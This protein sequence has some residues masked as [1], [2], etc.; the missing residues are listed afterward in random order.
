[1]STAAEI[2]PLLDHNSLEPPRLETD[3]RLSKPLKRLL[4]VL[5]FLILY[6]TRTQVKLFQNWVTYSCRPLQGTIYHPTSAQSSLQYPGVPPFCKIGSL[7]LATVC[8]IVHFVAVVISVGFWGRLGDHLQSRKLVLLVILSG[9]IL[10]DLTTILVVKL[11]LP[12]PPVIWLLFEAAYD[13]LFGGSAAVY[14]LLRAFAVDFSLP[15]QRAI[16]FTVLQGFSIVGNIV[17]GLLFS[18]L[19]NS[20]LFDGDHSVSA[21]RLAV[22]AFIVSVINTFYV[23]ACLPKTPPTSTDRNITSSNFIFTALSP[24]TT[25]ASTAKMGLLGL[26]T[27]ALSMTSSDSIR[28]LLFSLQ[29]VHH[30]VIDQCLFIILF[31]VQIIGTFVIV[32]VLITHCRVT[33]TTSIVASNRLL[34]TMIGFWTTISNLLAFIPSP[35]GVAFILFGVYTPAFVLD[36]LMSLLFTIGT[37]YFD[38]VGRSQEIGFLLSAM[39][40][41]QSFGG[42]LFYYVSLAI[43]RHPLSGPKSAFLLTPGLLAITTFSLF[44]LRGWETPDRHV[45]VESPEETSALPAPAEEENVRPNSSRAGV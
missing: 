25:F 24:F 34:A 15:N 35:H 22:F 2:E 31:V 32:P 14:A 39:A 3:H 45:L 38:A 41:L 36:G 9:L 4:R 23:A 8:T 27:L 11:S 16:L 42:V 37:M 7:D 18:L 40:G 1:M 30:P 13:G 19:F 29:Y 20:P 43:T 10:F 28:K 33:R 21:V 26:A 44:L 12:E 17:G 6:Q 5:P